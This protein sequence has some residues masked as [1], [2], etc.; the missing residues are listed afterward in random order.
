MTHRNIHYEAAFEDFL[1]SRGQPYVAVD[2]TKKALFASMAVKSFDFIVYGSDGPNLLVDIKGR[3]FPD[4]TP[5]A[6][7]HG[8]RVWENWITSEDAESLVKWQ[9]VFGDGFLAVLVFAYWIQGFPHR[10]PFE[11]VH[12]FREKHYAFVAISL[13]DYVAG[14]KPRSAKWQTMAMPSSLFAS[15]VVDVDDWL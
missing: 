14:A 1:R 12:V 4:S 10:S 7:R 8:I 5:G 11:D 6:K 2:E 13:V 15:Q 3:K 9:R